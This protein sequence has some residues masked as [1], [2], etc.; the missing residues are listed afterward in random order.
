MKLIRELVEQV[1]VIEEARGE[2]KETYITGIYLQAGLK[3]KNNRIYPPPV[4]EREVNRYVEECVKRNCAW[5]ELGHPDT[6]KLNEDRISHRITEMTRSGNDWHGKAIVCDTR[7]GQDV[8][9]MIKSGGRLG[10][11]SRGMGSL[12]TDAATGVHTVANDY[13]LMV[14]GD[15]VLNPS[16]PAA[17]LNTVM[18]GAEWW[19][20]E[21]GEWRQ[22]VREVREAVRSMGR[23]E[24]KDSKTTQ[25]L[26]EK[27]IKRLAEPEGDKNIL[28]LAEKAGV[29]P[30]RV[31]EIWESTIRDYPPGEALRRVKQRLGL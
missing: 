12:V 11:S 20:D 13:R 29:S 17:W 14:G 27:F 24:L 28:M 19:Q 25:R 30:A 4:L 15:I 23:T 22:G 16:A 1:E 9:A 31:R 18:E 21:R 5:G 8:K 2:V 7:N 3:N 10:I 26:F 6:P